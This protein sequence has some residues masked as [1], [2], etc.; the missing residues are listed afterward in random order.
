MMK[1]PSYETVHKTI[2]DIQDELVC[3]MW[4]AAL[5]FCERYTIE[6]EDLPAMVDKL[7]VQKLKLSAEHSRLIRKM[8]RQVMTNE[9]PLE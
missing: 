1:Q 6:P 4:E 5:E 7:T 9:L 2:I 8:N 3:T